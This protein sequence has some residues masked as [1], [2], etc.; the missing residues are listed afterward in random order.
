MP[1]YV[2]RGSK[3]DAFLNK[4]LL[5]HKIVEWDG[6]PERIRNFLKKPE[7]ANRLN[8]NGFQCGA[9]VMA[10]VHA[11]KGE[12]IDSNCKKSLHRLVGGRS[13]GGTLREIEKELTPE[14]REIYGL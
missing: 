13:K 4:D 5:S 10:V 1:G 14:Q 9:S 8:A 7:Y 6:T 12:P 11:F 3:P 2:Y